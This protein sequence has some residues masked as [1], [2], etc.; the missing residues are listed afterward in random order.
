MPFW[1]GKR[2]LITGHTGFKGAW[3]SHVLLSLG[4]DVHGMAL[5][6]EDSLGIYKQTDLDA[7][8][9]S[10]SLTDIRDRDATTR[11]IADVKPD[12]L[13][14]L[15]AQALVPDSYNDP[16]TCIE[17]NVAGTAHVLDAARTCGADRIA[18]INVT[19]D[20]CYLNL[21]KGVP[22]REGDPLGGHDPYSASKASADIIGS[23]FRSSF[24]RAF[25]YDVANARAGNVIG[26]GDWAARRLVPDLVRAH[27]Q[28]EQ[29]VLRRP[30]AVRPWQHV[31]EPVWGYIALAEELWQNP[32]D[33]ASDWNFGPDADD[34]R[35]VEEVA[36]LL[37]SRLGSTQGARVEAESFG[38]AEH[39]SLDVSKAKAKLN[40]RPVW[41]IETALEVTADWY[42]EVLRGA[43]MTAVTQAQIQRY[44]S[45]PQANGVRIDP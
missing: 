28:S 27:M 17:T 8:L 37:L 3:L 41:S 11:R 25:Q 9:S 12:I 26:G 4:A 43:D 2:V 30:N 1:Q 32:S 5:A 38:E 6:A 44:L 10:S 21:E 31:L 34:T 40:W 14:H 24:G 42:A 29:T 39:L 36:G 16:S 45:A 23:S 7:L 35:T 13:F 20:K 33:A 15:A 22:F 18:V 19:S